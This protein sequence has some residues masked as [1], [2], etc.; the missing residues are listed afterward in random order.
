[1]KKIVN[2]DNFLFG[3]C[4]NFTFLKRKFLI[5]LIY[6]ARTNFDLWK[7]TFD[8]CLKLSELIIVKMLNGSLDLLL[9]Q[10]RHVPYMKILI[11]VSTRALQ[12]G[13]VGLVDSRIISAQCIQ[14]Q[15]WP[16]GINAPSR[17]P[18]WHITQSSWSPRPP[19]STSTIDDGKSGGGGNTCG[20]IGS[21]MRGSGGGGP[22]IWGP[23]PFG[24]RTCNSAN[25]GTNERQRVDKVGKIHQ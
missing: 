14:T 4:H 19:A 1:M 17:M 20:E 25:E 22:H 8:F 6:V 12:I 7:K 2:G 11:V 16:H 18:S 15:R 10:L 3:K 13:Q 23:L 9:K 21:I 5:K 24:R